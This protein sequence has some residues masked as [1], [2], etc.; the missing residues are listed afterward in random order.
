MPAR[1]SAPA[2]TV[3]ARPAVT[4]APR[5]SGGEGSRPT[6]PNSRGL[7]ASPDLRPERRLRAREPRG[8]PG[9]RSATSPALSCPE[10]HLGLGIGATGVLGD[11]NGT[12]GQRPIGDNAGRGGGVAWTFFGSVT[13]PHRKN[14]GIRGEFGQTTCLHRRLGGRRRGSTSVLHQKN[15]GFGAEIQQKKSASPPSGSARREG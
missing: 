13:G 1:R 5:R 14:K 9:E 4:A 6:F 2:D 8:S 12:G 10:A 3:A 7:P 15:K 11:G